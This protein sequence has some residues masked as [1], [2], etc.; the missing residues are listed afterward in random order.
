MRVDLRHIKRRLLKVK[1]IWPLSLARK[2]QATFG[3]AVILVLALA[4]LIPYIWMGKLA[5]KGL[6]NAGRSRSKVLLDRHFQLEGP[7]QTL[8]VLDDT[9]QP[10]DANDTEIR[11]IRFAEDDPNL[12]A[13]F[14]KDVN[15]MVADIKDDEDRDDNV[16]V[17]KTEDGKETH[18]VRIF[19]ATDHCIDCH[20]Q[21]GTA[22][23][24][25]LNKPVGAALIR[26]RD[27]ARERGNTI[28]MN[29][30]WIFVA[31][32]IGGTGAIVAFY[33]IT[34]RLILRPIRQLRA[35]ANNV[36]EGNLETRSAIATRDEYEKLARA[37]NHMLD[38]L[39]ATQEK[40]RQA[41]KQLDAKIAELSKR[42]IEL[43]K[44]NK[45]K[46]EFLANISHEFKTP[47]NAILGFAQVLR[48]KPLGLR[49][50]KAQRYAENIITSGNSLLN[51]I[52]D[53][54]DLAKARAGKM[55]LHIQQVSAA[56]L[57]EALV[58]EFSLLADE[59]KIKVKLLVDSD[60]PLLVTDVGRVRQILYNFLSNALKF[61]PE[62]GR[63]E[64]QAIFPA[65]GSRDTGPEGR[66]IRLAVTDN[67]S[68]IA[69]T[70]KEKIFEKFRQADGSIT[71]ESTGSGLGL[72]IST[73]LAAM[74]A[75]SIGLESPP[76]GRK[77]GAMFWLDIPITLTENYDR[78]RRED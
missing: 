48:E 21:Q 7:G 14:G 52:N 62:R 29:T 73:E 38:V 76:P 39:Q 44:A 47:L 56:D 74:L 16:R 60:L 33:V 59:R 27:L 26:S 35:L 65:P 67:G 24:F 46:S 30:V 72:T 31:G 15:D 49:K 23:P 37:F 20:N 57:L 1:R 12:V 68:G 43:F 78:D 6:L 32:L 61:T 40:L 9:G 2:V 4:L 77:T 54:L 22:S 36:A 71:R 41:N 5:T 69:D 19:R 42:N 64:I 3:A 50:A 51:M 34:Q 53:L 13:E 8:R 58:S 17:L 28:F 66:M 63:I 18:Y 75:G 55:D 11:W 70:D 10:R 25:I 45:I